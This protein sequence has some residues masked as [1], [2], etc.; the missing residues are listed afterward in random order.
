M[1]AHYNNILIKTASYLSVIISSL[2][3]IIKIY[4]WLITD[5][6]AV[7]ASLLDSM[8]DISASLINIIAITFSLQPPDDKHRFGHEKF[9]DL[10]VFSQA[11]FFFSSSLLALAYSTKA[12]L[13]SSVVANPE[14]GSNAIYICIVLTIILLLYQTYVVKKTNSRLIAIDKLHYLVDLLSNAIVL[15]A[16]NLSQK[17]WFL[18]SLAGIVISLYLMHASYRFFRQAIKNLADEEFSDSDR[19]KIIAIVAKYKDV[20]GLYELKTRYAAHKPFIQ[21]HLE[22]DN[23][24][25]LREAHKISKKICQELLQHF[26]DGEII[27]HQYPAS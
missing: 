4:G 5:S 6:Q 7:F 25:Y 9:Q 1:S 17:F 10:A 2:I 22:M 12:L 11:I 13:F 20:K 23:S 27:I 26:P 15:I 3:I 21:F 14:E 18:D 24:M 8:L 16:I 19:E